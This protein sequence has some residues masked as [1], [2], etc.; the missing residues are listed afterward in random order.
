VS[1]EQPSEDRSPRRRRVCRGARYAQF[2]P[3]SVTGLVSQFEAFADDFS[4]LAHA[5]EAEVA[6]ALAAPEHLLVDPRQL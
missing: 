2:H 1:D 3:G 4:P 6:G 5:L